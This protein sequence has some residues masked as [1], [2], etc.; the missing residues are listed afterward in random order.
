[1]RLL[2]ST[3]IDADHVNHL[4][5][6]ALLEAVILGDGGSVHQQIVRLVLTRGAQVNL[7]DREGVTPLQHAL[8]RDQPEVAALLRAAGGLR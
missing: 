5:W 2:L 8:K 4:G 3:D 7:A 6:T 1:M